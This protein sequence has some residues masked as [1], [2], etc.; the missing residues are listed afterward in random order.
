MLIWLCPKENNAQCSIYNGGSDN[1]FFVE[2]CSSQKSV[3][4]QIYFEVSIGLDLTK[5]KSWTHSIFK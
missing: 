2:I 1:P 3:N 4:F 5:R